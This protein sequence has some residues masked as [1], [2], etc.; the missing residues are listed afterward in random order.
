MI[1]FLFGCI[2]GSSITWFVLSMYA[3]N[4]LR[5]LEYELVECRTRKYNKEQ[6]TSNNKQ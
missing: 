5:E 1:D 4:E 2:L 3:E 6:N